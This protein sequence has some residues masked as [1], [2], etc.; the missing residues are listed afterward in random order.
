MDKV[1]K[2]SDLAVNSEMGNRIM[3]LNLGCG[4]F[5]KYGYINVDIRKEVN[6]DLVVDL[7][8]FPYPFKDNTFDLVEAF[9]VLEHLNSPFEAMF[10]LHRI[11]KN[12]GELKIAVPHCSRGFSHPEHKAGFDVTFP[13]YFD[14]KYPQYFYGKEFKLKKLR[15]NWLGQ[16]YLRKQHLSKLTFF[17]LEVMGR[18]ISFFANLNPLLCAKLWCYWVG[19]FDEIY[20]EFICVK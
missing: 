10:E 20:M 16:K 8:K 13:Y 19:G 2:K 12:G 18:F 9:H 1:N 3:K 7:N 14:P 17:T 5:K 6:P 11:L 4:S 15:L